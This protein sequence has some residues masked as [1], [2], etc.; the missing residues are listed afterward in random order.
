MKDRIIDVDGVNSFLILRS[1]ECNS[2][3]DIAI[4]QKDVREL[5]NAKAAIAAGVKI[6][7]KQ[8]GINVNVIERVF[9]AGGF[10]SY[11]NIESALKIGL[12][13]KELTG[14]IESIGNAA[15]SGAVEGLLS[16]KMLGE[17]NVIKSRIKYVEL[18]GRPDFVEEYV[19]CMMF[20]A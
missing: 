14:K 4:T 11:I 6:L 10:G 13:P 18:S 8:A 3:I 17:A 19:E 16:A 7:I 12:L 20:E 1:E 15:G 9:L 5:Q 2:E